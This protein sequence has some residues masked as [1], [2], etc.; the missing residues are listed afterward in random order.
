M[1][2]I[3]LPHAHGSSINTLAFDK[4][5]I[6]SQHFNVSSEIFKTLSDPTR[7]RMFWLLC[8]ME[9]CVIN[10]SYL[11]NISSPAVSHHIKLLKEASLIVSR[12]DGKEVY[13]KV[14]DTEVCRLLHLMVEQ[15]MDIACPEKASSDGISSIEAVHSVHDYLVEHI[16]KRITIEELSSKFHINSTTLK[17][18]FKEQYGMSVAAHMKE[19]RM[20][21]A[22]ELLTR[23]N[24]SISKVAKAVSY[25]S[26]SK[27]TAAFKEKYGVL[28]SDYKSK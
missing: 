18:I 27:F 19:H 17:K 11:L 12:R 8:H 4:K 5:L 22:A 21:K 3:T 15:I 10:L 6:N 25:E 24:Y 2:K 1:E 14:A 9:E 13:Y 26:Q 16:D 23:T 7:I 28:P 20:E